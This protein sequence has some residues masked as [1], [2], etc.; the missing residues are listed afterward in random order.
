[1]PAMRQE[2][3][4]DATTDYDELGEWKAGGVSVPRFG[5]WWNRQTGEG[6]MRLTL[7]GMIAILGLVALMVF[8]ARHQWG[9]SLA[10]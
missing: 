2:I 1:M 8:I 3:L 9:T 7:V 10:A 4:V 5:M 6:S